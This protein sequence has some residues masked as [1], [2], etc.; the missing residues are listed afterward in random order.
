M[1]AGEDCHEGKRM[2]ILAH[3][4][5]FLTPVMVCIHQSSSDLLNQ[6]VVGKV[7]HLNVSML[8]LPSLQV[9]LKAISKSDESELAHVDLPVGDDGFVPPQNGW[10][11]ASSS[12]SPY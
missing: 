2:Y 9:I 7:G 10:F 4:I 3:A 5:Q 8:C 1:L 11:E 12:F 6:Q